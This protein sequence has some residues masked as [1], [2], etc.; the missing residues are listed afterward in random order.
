MRQWRRGKL[1]LRKLVD[2]SNIVTNDSSQVMMQTDDDSS[3]NSD[4]EEL[5][6]DEED[7]SIDDNLVG[8][9]AC[10][11]EIDCKNE[12]CYVV[13]V[14]LILKKKKTLQNWQKLNVKNYTHCYW[15]VG[16]FNEKP[17]ATSFTLPKSSADNIKQN[18]GMD[19]YCH[20]LNMNY[21]RFCTNILQ[22]NYKI[23]TV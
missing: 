17:W 8:D 18:S 14:S 4:C 2:A 9:D 12:I 21:R 3:Q 23:W 20:N 7:F 13:L 5:C 19:Y 11:T 15:R 1:W 10:W 22:T 16:R 6:P